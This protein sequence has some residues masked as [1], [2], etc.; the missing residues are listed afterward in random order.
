MD[1]RKAPNESPMGLSHY[2]AEKRRALSE[3]SETAGWSAGQLHEESVRRGGGCHGDPA[4][5]CPRG[6]WVLTDF[7]TWVACGT[8]GPGKEH[9]EDYRHEDE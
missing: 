8:H 2:E 6:G 4:E 3:E 9:P 7:D 5:D 1:P